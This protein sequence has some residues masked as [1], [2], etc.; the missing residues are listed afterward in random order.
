MEVIC[1]ENS[2]MYVKS[3]LSGLTHDPRDALGITVVNISTDSRCYL[4]IDD[5]NYLSVSTSGKLET[6]N[7][8]YLFSIERIIRPYEYQNY[9]LNDKLLFV[10]ETLDFSKYVQFLDKETT[11][12]EYE[13]N[14]KEY[15]SNIKIE[16]NINYILINILQDTNDNEDEVIDIINHYDGYLDLDL[17]KIYYEDTPEMITEILSDRSNDDVHCL[18]CLIKNVIRY[19]RKRF[20]HFDE[21]DRQDIIKQGITFYRLAE[22]MIKRTLVTDLLFMYRS[23]EYLLQEYPSIMELVNTRV[24]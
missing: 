20:E 9:H 6:S 8:P 18:L 22:I 17:Y 14:I 2:K 1:F 16:S 19:S 12:K 7:I 24:R 5:E 4:K 21:P 23:L 13:S 10:D 15:E 11:I 3:D